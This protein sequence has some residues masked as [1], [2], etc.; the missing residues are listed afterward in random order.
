[1]HI[2]APVVHEKL[3]RLYET[4]GN[5]AKAVEHL[6]EFVRGREGADPDLQPRVAAAQERIKALEG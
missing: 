1:M 2:P 6:R 3:G 4:A 5:T